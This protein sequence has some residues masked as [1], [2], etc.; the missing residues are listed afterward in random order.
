MRFGVL[1]NAKIAREKVAPAMIKA[2]HTITAVASRSQ[3]SA[4]TF[5]DAFDV[6]HTFADYDELLACD[7]V[8]AV[9]IPLPNHLHVPYALK[10]LEAGKHVLCEKP[11]A[12]DAEELE[13]LYAAAM[14]HDKVVMEAF[15]VCQ[16]QQWQ[17]IHETILPAIGP[18]RA[19]QG[20]FSYYN[21]SPDNVRNVAEWGGGGLLDIGCYTVLAGIWT[22]GIA[23]LNVQSMVDIDPDFD[24]DRLAAALLDFGEGRVLSMTVSTQLADYQRLTLLGERGW[25]ELDIPFNPDP[26]GAVITLAEAGGRGRGEPFTLAPQD[27]YVAMIDF[28]ASKVASEERWH[29]LDT[30]RMVIETLDRIR[31]SARLL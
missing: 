28:F 27:Q 20:A 30:S 3:E 4:R 13:P 29:N 12:R 16:H 14:K 2:G 23:P 24:T 5:A 6:T 21:R 19:I 7:E 10:A 17:A 8:D 22:F 26:A 9:Y 25:A 1:G 11:I 15:M 18:V 31:R